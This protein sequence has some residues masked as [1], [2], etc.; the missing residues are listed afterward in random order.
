MGSSHSP[1][2]RDAVTMTALVMRL[3]TQTVIV[4]LSGTSTWEVFKLVARSGAARALPDD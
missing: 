1:R 2:F 3:C 4:R